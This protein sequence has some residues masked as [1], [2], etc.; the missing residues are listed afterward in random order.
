MSGNFIFRS[1][2]DYQLTGGRLGCIRRTWARCRLT[3]YIGASRVSAW[4]SWRGRFVLKLRLFCLVGNNMLKFYHQ[5]TTDETLVD[6][7]NGLRSL[8]YQTRNTPDGL[9]LRTTPT[10]LR[11]LALVLRN[12]SLLLFRQLVEIAVVDRLLSAGRFLVSYSF[13]SH[14]TN[15]RVIVQIAAGETSILPSL[16]SAFTNGQRFFA[17][18]S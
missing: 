4:P 16:A 5:P 3:F 1:C 10:K 11:Q 9:V 17:S 18:A 2:P 14:V 8:V 15:Q 13:L 6:L 7:Q 12:S